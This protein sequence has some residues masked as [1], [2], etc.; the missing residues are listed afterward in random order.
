[1]S[2]KIILTVEEDLTEAERDKLRGLLRD[3]FYE[4]AGARTPARVYVADRYPVTDG[5][6]FPVGP[7]REAKIA[8]VETR[9]TLARKL[10]HATFALESTFDPPREY[11]VLE[12]YSDMDARAVPVAQAMVTKAYRITSPTNSTEPDATGFSDD[13]TIPRS[14]PSAPTRIS[15]KV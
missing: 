8:E 9:I 2:T 14:D 10:H 11:P 3:A 5:T 15:V 4:F 7:R 1:M 6:P 12:S 13:P